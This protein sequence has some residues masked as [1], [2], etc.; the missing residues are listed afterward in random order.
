MPDSGTL[1]SFLFTCIAIELTPGP[2]MSYLALLSAMQGRKAGFAAVIGIASG[3]LLIG[4]LSALGAAA[5]VTESPVIYHALRWVG[6]CYLLWLAVDCWR[7]S[8]AM[9]AARSIVDK[10]LVLRGFVIN[11]LN[12][13]AVLFY[14]TLLPSFTNP[15]APLL[16]QTL[17]LTVLSVS[18]ATIVHMGIVLLGARAKPYLTNARI[19]Q[20]VRHF[21]A[22][23]LVLV[24][25]WFAVATRMF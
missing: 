1:I 3:L 8:N 23:L 16:P 24:A 10:R 6:V 14:I 17:M 18:I 21:F 11:M 15:H 20:H 7:S 4:V 19:A 22:A 9:A 12:P 25:V 13:K 5:I 2:N